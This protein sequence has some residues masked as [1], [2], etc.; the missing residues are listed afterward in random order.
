MLDAINAGIDSLRAALRESKAVVALTG[1]GVSAESGIPTF[2]GAGG[3]WRSFRPEQL[4][5]P[6]AFARDPR[7][8]WEW[9]DW[10]RGVIC[11]AEPNPGHAALAEIERRK[12]GGFTVITQ[13]V[14]GLH[15]RA[16]NRRLVKLHG[17]IWRTRCVECG[18]V[19][20]NHD[21][22]LTVIPPHCPCDGL[23]RPDVIWFGEALSALE[24]EGAVEAARH[25]DLFMLIG[26][27]AMVYPA[28][29]LVELGHEAG[30][31]VAIIN[32]ETTPFS[33][34]AQWRL[35]GAAGE[36]L[37]LLLESW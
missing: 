11:R 32:P 27:S 12:G 24:W 31:R 10:R 5:T 33:E 16:G 17:D 14:D 37:P 36:I 35:E 3:L 26:T 18:T 13:N 15:D 9:Y 21:V 6:E 4:A 7:L 23:L 29:G 34:R 8:V 20:L 25:A 22:P 1:A 28:A 2:R 19:T 30:A